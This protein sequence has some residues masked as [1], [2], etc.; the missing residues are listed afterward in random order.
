MKC[1]HPS[2]DLWL[3]DCHYYTQIY[4]KGIK[5]LFDILYKVKE[6]VHLERK[7]M[8]PHYTK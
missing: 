4:W 5:Q 7:F 8:C 3:N 1:K 6:Y 2:I